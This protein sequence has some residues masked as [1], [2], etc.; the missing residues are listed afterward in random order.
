MGRSPRAPDHR[1]IDRPGFIDVLLQDRGNDL[2]D[3]DHRFLS[4]LQ[5]LAL[6]PLREFILDEI[7]TGCEQQQEADENPPRRAGRS[8]RLS[9]RASSPTLR[10]IAMPT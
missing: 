3:I 7:Q 4:R 5:I 9:I 8:A 10:P 2:R 6:D 1:E